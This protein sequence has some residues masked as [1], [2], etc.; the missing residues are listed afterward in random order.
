[1]TYR[2]LTGENS[3]TIT[4][5]W[6]TTGFDKGNY[7]IS[8]YATPVPGETDTADNTLTGGWVVVAMVGDITGP[9]GWP[10]GKCD[11]RDVALVARHFGQ[12][13]PP[14]PAN[15]DLTGSTLGVQDGIIDM[16]DVGIVSRYFGEID[17]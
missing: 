1:M 7:S 6:N 8:A 5:T 4:S 17:P 11:M 9:D 15:C 3:T 14:A 2:A 16:R 12:K 13:V 10:D